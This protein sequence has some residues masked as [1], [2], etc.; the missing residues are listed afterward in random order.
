MRKPNKPMIKNMRHDVL[1]RLPAGEEIRKRYAAFWQGSGL[2]RAILQVTAVR[3]DAPPPDPTDAPP[4]DPADCLDWFLNPERVLPRLE[5]QLARGYWAGDAF[6]LVAP[7]SPNLVAIQAAYL[8]GHYHVASGTAW[9]DPLIDDWETRRHL[10]VDPRNPWWLA[11]CELLAAGAEAF[12]DRAIIAIPDLQGGGQIVDLLRGTERLAMDLAENSE[13]VSRM[14][15]EVDDTWLQYWTECCR[16]ARS[17]LNGYA[18]WVGFWCEQPAVTVECDFCCMISPAMFQEVFVPSLRRQTA[19]AE[20]A[21]FHLDGP[22]A[23]RHLDALLDLPDLD[24]IQWV[25]GPGHTA[26]PEWLPLFRRIQEA[27]RRVIVRCSP[28]DAELLMRE[29]RPDGLLIQIGFQCPQAAD[30]FVIRNAG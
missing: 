11:T 20:H 28:E 7:V 18:D 12:A 4:P 9:C 22:D 8:G 5:R 1:D 16:L 21:V 13:P 10:D 24:G 27:D 30:D 14:L 17:P 6:P 3:S 23:I 2:D 29:L 15:E 26:M 19:M 25:P